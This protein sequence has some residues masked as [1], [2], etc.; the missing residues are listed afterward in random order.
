MTKKYKEIAAR[1]AEVCRFIVRRNLKDAFER[2]DSWIAGVEH[3]LPLREKR[4]ELENT[5]RTMLSYAEAGFADPERERILERL[6][7]GAFSLAD[8]LKEIALLQNFPENYEFT[9]IR[10]YRNSPT[11]DTAQIIARLEELDSA[12]SLFEFI[13]NDFATEKSGENDAVLREKTQAQLF[14]RWWLV[15]NHSADEM[16]D[17][18]NFVGQEQ[19][20][21]L[22]QSMAVSA[23]TLNL[24][25]HFNEQKLLFLFK[26]SLFPNDEIRQRALVGL[27]ICLM[28]YKYRLDFYPEIKKELANFTENEDAKK[29]LLM[30]IIQFIRSFD[31]EALTKRIHKE[32]FPEINKIT[33]LLRNKIKLDDVH[34][35]D[36]FEEKNPEWQT[37]IE[38]SGVGDKLREISELQLEGADVFMSTFATLK[39]FPFFG[40][41][42]NWFLPFSEQHTAVQKVI[43]E[44]EKNLISLFSKNPVMCNSDKYSFCLSLVGMPKSQRDMISKGMAFE[45]AELEKMSGEEKLLNKQNDSEFISNQYIQDLYRF[46]KLYPYRADF[47]NPFGGNLAFHNVDLLARLGFGFDEKKQIADFYFSKNHCDKAIELYENLI[48]EAPTNAEIYQKIGY[49]YQYANDFERALD[50]YLKAETIKHND[51]W[52][53]KKI[54]FCYKML[55][56]YDN[57]F[58]YYQQ[59]SELKSGASQMTPDNTNL[60]L[61]VGH[62]LLNLGEYDEALNQYFKVEY[63]A[64]DNAKVRK[65]VAWCSFLAN[66]PEQAQ[67]YYKKLIDEAP[68]SDDFLNAG[69][70]EWVSGNKISALDFY[71][72]S[73][74][75]SNIEAF[76]SAFEQDRELL[77]QKGVEPGDVPLMLDMLR[78][79]I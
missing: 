63:L 40:E 26:I 68:A 67:R 79:R 11:Q 56:Q 58:A 32:I 71:E 74:K 29:R 70:V 5:Y 46:Y 19:G 45:S 73:V 2:L 36:D 1:H 41:T 21:V 3:F 43:A 34:T 42:M 27:I 16:T 18:Y 53:L 38:Q 22:D 20:S 44:D 25:R 7:A 35:A 9:R 76:L 31:T 39:H 30:I 64:P 4:E 23:L 47:A 65:A 17:L 78:Y 24:I 50:N 48:T 13:G 12:L 6:I 55:R 15:S 10:D 77:L 59:V 69:H 49:C 61:N 51:S 54:A 66:K 14:S 52:T 33:P 8:D 57:A 62:C 60:L 72:K 37:L 75:N 28:R